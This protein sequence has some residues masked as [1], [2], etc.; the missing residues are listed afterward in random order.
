[1]LWSH[2]PVGSIGKKR[3]QISALEPIDGLKWTIAHF[4]EN[5]TFRALRSWIGAHKS[6]NRIKIFR[7]E[8][9]VGPNQLDWFT[10]LMVFCDINLPESELSILLDQ[11]SFERLSGRKKGV[12]DRKSKLRKGV[13]G[14]WRNHFDCSVE[15][16]FEDAAGDLLSAFGYK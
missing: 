13:A 15:L 10:K 8:D 6:D 7:Y 14:D 12:E 3:E 16:G 9:F 2:R 1:M 5:G 4:V 11:H